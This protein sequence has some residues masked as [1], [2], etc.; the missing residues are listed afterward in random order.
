MGRRHRRIR[1]RRTIGAVMALIAIAA[2]AIVT[3]ELVRRYWPGRVHTGSASAHGATI[4]RYDLHSRFVHE[5]L[6]QTAAI[7]PGGGTGRPLLV[8][9]HGRGGGGNESNSNEHFYAALRAQGAKAPDV[10]F[11]N[12]GDHSYFHRRASGDWAHYVL[13]EVIPAA[14]RRLHA[15]PRR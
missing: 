6:P 13:D 14:V 2:V 1:R 4:V 11:P 3:I 12:G 10:V 9:L 5:T 8:F 7:P 15:D